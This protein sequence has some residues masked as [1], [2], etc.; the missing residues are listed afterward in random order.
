MSDNTS[1]PLFPLKLIEDQPIGDSGPLEL[2]METYS[3]VIAGAAIGTDGPFTIGIYATWG[4]GK[5]SLLKRAFHLIEKDA[6]SSDVITVWFNAWQ[7]ER[8]DHPMVPLVATI[9]RAIEEKQ[10]LKRKVRAALKEGW[11][12]L[13]RSLRAIA[14]GFEAKSKVG[15]PGFA[16]VEAGFVA[17]DMVD[18][19]DALGTHSDPLLD[20]SL[21]Y[22]AFRL[23][24]QS[25]RVVKPP[26][27]VVFIDDLD[28]CL[29]RN[30][31]HLLESIKLVLAQ[32]G[33]VFVIALDPQIVEQYIENMYK[34]DFGVEDYAVA[35]AKYLDKIIQLPFRIPSHQ[36]RFKEYVNQLVSERTKGFDAETTR[37]LAANVEVLA[38][39]ADHNPRC[40]LRLINGLLT[41]CAVLRAVGE[42]E[43]DPPTIACLAVSGVLRDAIGPLYWELSKD[44]MLC[45]A[46]AYGSGRPMEARWVE[47]LALPTQ[48]GEVKKRIIGA[49]AA[50]R[51]LATVLD[52]PDAGHVWL[53]KSHLRKEVDEFSLSHI[54]D[55]IPAEEA[56]DEASLQFDRWD[57]RDGVP[58]PGTRARSSGIHAW[59]PGLKNSQIWFVPLDTEVSC[60]AIHPLCR[61]IVTGGADNVIRWW[62]PQTGRLVREDEGHGGPIRCAAVSADGK[63]VATGSVDGTVR[64]WS[65]DSKEGRVNTDH[66]S[67]VRCLAFSPDGDFVASGSDDGK[68]RVS[69]YPDSMNSRVLGSHDGWVTAVAVSGDSRRI[70]TGSYD[71]TVREWQLDAQRATPKMV[72][73]GG[74]VTSLVL[75]SDDGKAVVATYEGEVSVCDLRS[76]TRIDAVPGVFGAVRCLSLANGRSR[77]LM[78]SLSGSVWAWDIGAID[79]ELVYN[80]HWHAVRAI[81]VS[82]DDRLAVS[83]E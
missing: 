21:Y 57:N 71:L 79:S 43:P 78:G 49:L 56:Y 30:A 19:Y 12:D 45:D 44:Q 5:T 53:T 39:G 65:P 37:A 63:H 59:R 17:K 9:V 61:W 51:Y 52:M 26:R 42:G 80:L 68:V 73:V 72:T 16:E 40:V 81:A 69:G 3:Q 38:A 54:P 15:V 46:I 14:Y 32:R 13:G 22:N 7:F 41:A 70:V 31:L 83:T 1:I 27:V 74:C 36:R 4:C 10:R 77:V 60:V 18:R 11:N 76:G 24:E 55:T 34:K 33:F 20:R 64:V 28:R 67:P 2:G 50:R 47:P 23:L 66:G 29:P 6:A 48:D 25:T 8:D 82:C 62:D 35:G 75:L 58:Q